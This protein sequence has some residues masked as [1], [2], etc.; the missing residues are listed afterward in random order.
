MA[1]PETIFA[2]PLKE[3]VARQLYIAVL[4]FVAAVYVSPLVE[5]GES[6]PGASGMLELAKGN[7]V[8]DVVVDGEPW[9]WYLDYVYGEFPI[10]DGADFV[11]QGKVYVLDRVSTSMVTVRVK[12]AM[13]AEVAA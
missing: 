4:L 1:V 9:R 3:A 8:W 12:V 11:Y 6:V 2:I 10:A 7:F 13:S 5:A